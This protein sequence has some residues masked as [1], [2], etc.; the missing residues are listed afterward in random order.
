[1]TTINVVQGFGLTDTN[2]VPALIAQPTK[3]KHSELVDMLT[4]ESHLFHWKNRID[5]QT[6]EIHITEN[7]IKKD[8]LVIYVPWQ[9]MYECKLEKEDVVFMIANVLIR[10]MQTSQNINTSF[11]ATDVYKAELIPIISQLVGSLDESY[12]SD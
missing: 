4:N 9:T 6:I 7:E 10:T 8:T 12:L 11:K 3:N 1:M 5:L 2:L